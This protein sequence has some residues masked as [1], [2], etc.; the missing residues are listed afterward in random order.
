MYTH[1]HTLVQIKCK[2]NIIYFIRG[3]WSEK[4]PI[5]YSDQQTY[6]MIS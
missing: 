5:I 3:G 1:T 2:N 6:K 4:K